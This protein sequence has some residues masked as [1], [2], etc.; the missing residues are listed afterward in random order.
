MLAASLLFAVMGVCVK[1]ASVRFS[2]PELVFWRGGIALVT[3]GGWMLWQGQPLATPYVRAHLWRGLAGTVALGASFTA[4]SLLPLS[5]AVTLGYTSPLF[6]ALLLGVWLR[7]PIRPATQAAL[8]LGFFGLLLLLRPTLEAAQWL[9]A[10]CGLVCGML[11]AVAYLNVRTLG[12]LGEPVWRT[13]FY[14]SLATTLGGLPW[15]LV[16]RA[17]SPRLL[18]WI[19]VLGIGVCGVLAQLCLTHA[20]KH[21][22]ALVAASLSYSTVLFSSVLALFIWGEVLPWIA[23]VGM[24]CIMVAGV[25]AMSFST[26]PGRAD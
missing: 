20:Y 7:E 15:L 23:Y 2:A 1:L 12:T 22:R 25:M 8:A 5:T 6:L 13:V 3:V 4:M 26:P 9:G 19:W 21:G 11:S 24:L 10:L 16:G 14:F 17:Q 18:D